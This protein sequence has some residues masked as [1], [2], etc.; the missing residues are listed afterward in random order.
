M[1]LLYLAKSKQ[2]YLTLINKLAKNKTFYQTICKKI[3]EK[4]IF[5]LMIEKALMNGIPF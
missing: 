3:G 2:D 4:N 5:Y 1:D